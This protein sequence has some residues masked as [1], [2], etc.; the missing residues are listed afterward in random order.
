MLIMAASAGA[1]VAFGQSEGLDTMPPE[2]DIWCCAEPG[3]NSWVVERL[4]PIQR[5][6]ALRHEAFIR[7][8]VPIEYSNRTSP[9]PAAAGVIRSGAVLYDKH[10]AA[11]HG[12]K[13]MGDGEAGND[14]LPSPAL[15]AFMIQYPRSIDG[16]L[17]WTISEGGEAFGTEMPA[18]KDVLMD[19]EIWEI[20]AYM[21]A[22][23]PEK[24]TAVAE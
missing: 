14:L 18:F 6:R 20:V 15:L 17:L 23:F 2:G 5:R 11:C 4:N 12:G 8:G 24:S 7:D 9:Y 13:G 1:Q 16:Y 3:V 21:R 10:C 19:R 22:G